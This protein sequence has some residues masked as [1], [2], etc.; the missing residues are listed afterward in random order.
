MEQY[1]LFPENDLRVETPFTD[2]V[3]CSLGTFTQSPRQLQQLLQG[4]G[5]DY[6]TSTRPSR[7]VHFVLVGRDAPQDQLQ[8]LQTLAFHGFRPCLLHQAELDEI[9]Q[10]H[11]A[12]YRVPKEIS[13]DLRLTLQH[14]EQFHVDYTT[15]MNPLYTKELFVAPDTITP[16][17]ELYQMLG[18]RGIYANAYIDDTTDVLLVSDATLSRLRNG[19]TDDVLHTIEQKYNESRSPSYRYVMTTEGELLQWMKQQAK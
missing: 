9:L 7:N 5:A 4:M 1:S 14:Y 18:D 6:K 13:K 16:Q 15:A 12:D 8:Y 10:G 19:Q 17:A 11:Y 2:R 3:V